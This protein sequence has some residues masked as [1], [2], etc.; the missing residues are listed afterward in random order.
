MKYEMEFPE[1]VK[2]V[3]I[4]EQK[5]FDGQ[6]FPLILT[7]VDSHKNFDSAYWLQ[8]TKDNVEHINS[9]LLKYGTIL[10]RQFPFTEPVN[11]DEFAKAFGFEEFPYIG[12]VAVREPIVGNV[13]TSAES[14]PEAFISFH[15]EM[16]HVESHPK[17]DLND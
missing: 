5:E 10:F 16:A 8:W 14:P 15:H 12:G 4:P 13:Y 17:V 1:G 9:I 11:F 2:S 3:R 6:L 7:P